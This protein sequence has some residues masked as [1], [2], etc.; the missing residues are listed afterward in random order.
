[1]SNTNHVF[2]L[3]DFRSPES[4]DH[5][6]RIDD[7]WRHVETVRVRTFLTLPASLCVFGK[8]ILE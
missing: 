3:L 2:C 4:L 7:D 1:M 6:E 5:L 8:V